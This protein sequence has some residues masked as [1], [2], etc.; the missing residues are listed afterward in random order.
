M[1][2]AFYGLYAWVG[3]VFQ[4]RRGEESEPV[5]LVSVVARDEI[6]HNDLSRVGINS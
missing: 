6:F 4:P 1:D 2:Y 3:Q 5:F